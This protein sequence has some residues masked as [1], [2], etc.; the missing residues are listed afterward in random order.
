MNPTNSNR[1]RARRGFT[2][3]ELLIVVLVG[4]VVSAMSFGRMHNIILQQRIARAATSMQG[5][6]EAAFALAAR[7]RQPI[8]IAWGAATMQLGVTDRAGAVTYRHTN[9]GPDAY[10]LAS[11]NVAFSEI[12]RASC[13]ERV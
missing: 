1:R 12:G 2:L 10:G 3:I 9:L 13:R 5:D 11:S 6:L 4:G 8:R 7:N